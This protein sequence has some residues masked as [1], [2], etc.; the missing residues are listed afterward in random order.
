MLEKVRSRVLPLSWVGTS[1][2]VSNARPLS[3]AYSF[4]YASLYL[5][6]S[7]LCHKELIA[8]KS[9]PIKVERL[10]LI[11]L[12]LRWVGSWEPRPGGRYMLTISY[13]YWGRW[14]S[15]IF[16]QSRFLETYALMFLF[17]YVNTLGVPA[18]GG[19]NMR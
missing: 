9:P 14:R 19:L 18:A 17:T 6:S 4:I 3:R 15:R 13:R 16:K 1:I 10:G 7:V 12:I 11:A 5:L 8:L 2:S